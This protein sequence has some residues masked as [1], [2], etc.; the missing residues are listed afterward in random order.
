MTFFNEVSTF[1]DAKKLYKKLALEFHPDKGGDVEVMK[2]INAE[3]DFICAKILKG[4][5]LTD[6]EI[7]D[8]IRLSQEFREKIQPIA[9]LPLEIEIVNKWIWVSGNT[10]Q[11]RSILKEL[12]YMWASAKKMWFYRNENDKTVNRFGEM[13]IGEI[14]AKYGSQKVSNFKTYAI[15]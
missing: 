5:K 11:F 9:N 4:E 7:N 15:A 13:S 3:Y 1:A 12:G 6:S 14:R 10:Y 8:E 2:Q